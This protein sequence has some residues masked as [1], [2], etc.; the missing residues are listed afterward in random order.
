Y[1]GSWHEA[2]LFS[3]RATIS[4]Q[5]LASDGEKDNRKTAESL[6]NFVSGGPTECGLAV[7]RTIGDDSQLARLIADELHLRGAWPWT[8]ESTPH[9]RANG[10]RIVLV[11]ERDSSYGSLFPATFQNAFGDRLV[12]KHQPELR[13]DILHEITYLRGLDGVI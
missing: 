7:L 6:L 8:D 5:A 3:G 4:V 13:E 9:A 1:F 2:T 12:Q 11:T 10:R